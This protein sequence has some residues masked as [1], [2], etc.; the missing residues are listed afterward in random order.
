MTS[1]W[2]YGSEFHWSVP[3]EGAAAPR[4][5]GGA[6]WL[7]TGRDAL[8]TLVEHG[9]RQRG[10]RRIW[11]PTYVCLE[12]VEAVLSTGLETLAY[13]DGPDD[14]PAASVALDFAPGDVL[15][16]VNHFGIR[17]SPLMASLDRSEVAVIEDH[18]H[19]PWSA[20]AAQSDADF[21][22]A[23]LR[24]TLPLPDGA[25]LWSPRGETLPPAPPVSQVRRLA[26]QNKR[27][28]M[29]L[30]SQYLEDR[31]VSK[32]AFRTLLLAGE[33]DL[34]LGEPSGMT[35]ESLA[36]VHRLPVLAWRAKRQE[37]HRFLTA[38]L[39]GVSGVRLLAGTAPGTCP[40][41][42]VLVFDTPQRRQFV[43]R[44]LID[45]NVYP[46]VLWPL[47]DALWTDIP[48]WHRNLS[49][50]TLSL[51]CDMRYGR[52]DL[53]RVATAVSRATGEYADGRGAARSRSGEVKQ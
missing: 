3:D 21:A 34:A 23:S 9:R 48:A 49:R 39:A 38:R 6:I 44:R 12:L 10:W 41:S 27:D 52:A 42:A 14:G 20:W 8:R 18:T 1:R 46:A 17:T 35:P 19:D 5:P 26:S 51:P 24:K 33:H 40:F 32:E 2:E 36:L 25:V 29:L 13:A 45:Q 53:E 22:I 4:L 43:R 37:N 7:A 11:I 30:K 31:D 16:L 28:G 15:L 50:C 47:E